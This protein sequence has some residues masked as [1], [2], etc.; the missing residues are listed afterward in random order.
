MGLAPLSSVATFYRY[1]NFV[2]ET[3]LVDSPQSIVDRPMLSATKSSVYR[4]FHKC[5]TNMY[6]Y[7]KFYSKAPIYTSKG[8]N[9]RFFKGLKFKIQEC[10]KL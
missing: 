8:H 7:F 3:A 9:L 5:F 1:I 4:D 10:F 2:K 6:Q